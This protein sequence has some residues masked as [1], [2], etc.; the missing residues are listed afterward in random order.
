MLQLSTIRS[1][2]IL[3]SFYRVT[4]RNKIVSAEVNSQIL[5][6]ALLGIVYW[7]PKS[8]SE[9]FLKLNCI[10]VYVVLNGDHTSLD[11]NLLVPT[12]SSIGTKRR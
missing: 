3:Y 4:G 8:A 12:K 1:F 6:L 5:S 9:P 2:Q 10:E 11:L 7:C